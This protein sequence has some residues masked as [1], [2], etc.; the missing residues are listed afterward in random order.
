MILIKFPRAGGNIYKDTSAYYFMREE[1]ELFI[2][3][4]GFQSCYM[5]VAERMRL[6]IVTATF[7]EMYPCSF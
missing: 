6:F 1:I 3:P 2:H 5:R 7:R 4:T